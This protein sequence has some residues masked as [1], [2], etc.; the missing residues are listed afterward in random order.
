[1]EKE[2]QGKDRADQKDGGCA[3][4]KNEEDRMQD[5]GKNIFLWIL[6][7]IGTA[8]LISC[9]R[10][11][12]SDSENVDVYEMESAGNG[13]AAAGRESDIA[14]TGAAES[15][16]A[17][18]AAEMSMAEN[19]VAE[20]GAAEGAAGKSMAEDDVSG[21]GTAESDAA[22]DGRTDTGRRSTGNGTG[23]TGMSAASPEGRQGG[24]EAKPGQE[25]SGSGTEDDTAPGEIPLLPET[26]GEI[27]GFVP[28]G[29]ELMD[30]VELDF[31]E[32][33]VTDYI[34]VLEAALVDAEDAWHSGKPRIL[35][36]A[37]G[38]GTGGYRLD[39]QDINLIR[40][41]AEGG[42]FG[43]PYMPLTAKGTSFTT[44]AY[45]GSA[46]RWSEDYTYTWQEGVWRLTASE[47]TYGYGGY[48]T[49][50][51]RNDWMSG[52]GIRKERSSEFSDM[53]KIL[54]SGDDW[55]SAPYDLE[56][57]LPLDGP[58]TL[59]Q[60]GK[61]WW[62][63]KE[64][65][66]DWEVESVTCAAGAEISEEKVT[67]PDEAYLEYCDED[68]VLY[69]F[70]DRDSGQ[71]YL[72]MY[73]FEDRT[74]TVAA[75]EKGAIGFPEIYKGRIYYTAAIVENVRYKTWQDGGERTAEEEDTVGV[76]LNR[77][78]IDGTGKETV[79]EYRYPEDEQEI[80]ENGI[81]YLALN[82]EIGGEQIVAEVYI[83]DEPHPFYRMNIDGSGLERIGQV[84]KE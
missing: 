1:M 12:G 47:T 35:F 2:F 29:W 65:V 37:A 13:A 36:A 15:G 23:E 67:R 70:S 73:R 21:S 82:Y 78:A 50:Y 74:L 66:T 3:Q 39:F 53:E 55:D 4:T 81:P 45:G 34:G 71:Y 16:M 27:A 18:G 56:Y 8:S 19:G 44:H 58:V 33:G 38:E 30:S 54:D 43:D 42:V 40:T 83:G 32:D 48:T 80:R 10:S 61:R 26:A 77:T 11:S 24:T 22:K 6:I 17:E 41:R 57:E 7:G 64:R 20:S 52:T 72:A 28:E 59:E 79:F 75:R 60:A 84:P 31:N 49:S 25:E 14:E 68:C 46:W 5:K 9:G 51:G 76:R 69:S 63:A 62:L